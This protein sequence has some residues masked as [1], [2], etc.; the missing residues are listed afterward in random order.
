MANK[1]EITN[2]SLAT[3]TN[4]AQSN[5]SKY[6]KHLQNLGYVEVKRKSGK[7]K[8]WTVAPKIKWVLLEEPKQKHIVKYMP[9][10]I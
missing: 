2:K 7:D 4:T 8:F 10:K 9:P 5:I 3:G 1:E 6:L